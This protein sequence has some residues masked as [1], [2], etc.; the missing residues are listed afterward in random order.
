MARLLYHSLRQSPALMRILWLVLRYDAF[1]LSEQKGRLTAL[2]LFCRWCKRTDLPARQGERIAMLL[3]QLGP[4]FI[5]AG[6]IL[7]LR[8]DLIGAELADDLGKLRDRLPPF[9]FSAVKSSL[10]SEFGQ[11]LTTI[12]QSFSPEPVAAASIAQVHF[13]ITTEG[14][15]VAVKLLRPAI[16]RAFARD[17]ELFTCLA[18]LLEY[19]L[20][21]ANRLKPLAVVE[22]LAQSVKLEMDLRLEGAA[23]AEMGENFNN[24]PTFLVPHIVWPLTCRRI[25]TTSRIEGFPLHD[26]A[27]WQAAGHAPSLILEK[28]AIACF[29]QVFRDGFF[30]ADPHPGNLFVTPAGNI[31]AVDF[32]IMGRLDVSTRQ[33]LADMILAFMR[34]DWLLA[35]QI[36][37]A[38]GYVPPHHSLETFAQ[39]CR[40]IGEPIM[41]RP[42]GEISI[43]R[44]LGQ[45]FEVTAQFDMPTQPQLLLLQKWMLTVEGLARLIDP[46][47]NLWSLI[48]APIE[49]WILLNK[50]LP[51]RAKLEWQNAASVLR[52]LPG[53]LELSETA[54][55]LMVAG[56]GGGAQHQGQGSSANNTA[57]LL[58]SR[59]H[60]LHFAS[61]SARVLGL[62][63][64]GGWLAVFFLLGYIVGS[65]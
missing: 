39:A 31:A 35:A 17:L 21:Q 10:E 32:G 33:F 45:L 49:E 36:H 27:R 15:P 24:D 14:T 53:L 47:A 6:Q 18:A 54:L 7:S 58:A 9:A 60:H 64:R 1:V 11:P 62:L 38:A 30:H 57:A 51:Q 48:A 44:L 42:L 46:G 61:P 56:E 25:L 55:R 34:R 12:F 26:V 20:P 29:R 5:K 8:A 65:V 3:Q 63:V 50:S 52:R 41:D 22:T 4:S 23:A 40:A 2:S 28:L 19:W 16:E 37:F 13:A 59:H 43:G